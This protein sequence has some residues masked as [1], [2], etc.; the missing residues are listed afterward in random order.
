[1]QTDIAVIGAGMV[2]ATLC[3][4]LADSGL[5]ITLVDAGSL[6]PQPFSAQAS[7]EP[8]VS[9]LSAASQRILQRLNVWPGIIGRRACPYQH[10]QVWD[11]SGTGQVRF[12]SEDLGAV[13]LGHIVE[14]RWVQDALLEQIEQRERIRCLPHHRLETL[15]PLAESWLLR[16]ADGHELRCRLLVAADGARSAVRQ[17]RQT[18]T[19]EWDYLHH[20]IVTSVQCE[21][22][23]QHTAWQRF[24]DNGPLAFLPLAHP[25]EQW[26]SIVWST[27]PEEAN[28]VMA[29]DDT[30]FCAALERAFEGRLGR[31]L[32]ADRRLSIPLRQ[33][34]AKRYIEPGLALIGDAA[35]TIHPLA[36]QGVNLGFLDA[37]VLA[38]VILHAQQRGEDMGSLQTL[39]RFERRRMPDNLSMMAAMQGFERLFQADSLPLRWA[40]NTGLKWVQRLPAVQGAF[41]RHA[42]GESGDLPELARP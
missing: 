23:H 1:M 7:F 8:R 26:C 9:A 6:T 32:H 33:R 21:Q 36:G 25:S 20:A 2:G 31:V 38:E 12:S 14:N 13:R 29:L 42:L 17:L 39:S 27:T 40:R 4:A 5:D 18:E 37:A 35:H 19:R 16:F 11:G 15:E 34:H 41:V 28:A 3:L 10:M 30:A 24:T 22:P